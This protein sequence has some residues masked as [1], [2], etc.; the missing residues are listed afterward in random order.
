VEPKQIPKIILRGNHEAAR[1]MAR[2][3]MRQLDILK[4]LMSFGKLKQDVRRVEFIDG[5]EIICRSAFGIEDIQIYVPEKIAERE[6]T[7]QH[8]VY[9]TISDYVVI[10]SL[11]TGEIAEDIYDNEGNIEDEDGN[12]LVTFPCHKDKLVRWLEGISGK[13]T[14]QILK[15]NPEGNRDYILDNQ[16]DIGNESRVEFYNQYDPSREYYYGVGSPCAWDNLV[17]NT[18]EN[19]CPP[20]PNPRSNCRVRT[21]IEHDTPQPGYIINSDLAS[22]DNS[23]KA[24]TYGYRFYAEGDPYHWRDDTA[25]YLEPYR[26]KSKLLYLCSYPG[27]FYLRTSP[28]P[29]KLI[30]FGRPE[31]ASYAEPVKMGSACT[32]FSCV[33]SKLAAYEGWYL[34][35]LRQAGRTF[36]FVTVFGEF[37]A[38][39]TP[40]RG[41]DE[42]YISLYEVIRG[43]F[44][45]ENDCFNLQQEEGVC[46][47]HQHSDW[48]NPPGLGHCTVLERSELDRI[49]S[50]SNRFGISWC[51]SLTPRDEF[52]EDGKI[53]RKAKISG[54]YRVLLHFYMGGFHQF[55]HSCSTQAGGPAGPLQCIQETII[56]ETLVER[57]S[58]VQATI[59]LEKPEKYPKE[60]D[61][62]C[63]RYISCEEGTPE[64]IDGQKR[65]IRLRYKRPNEYAGHE[66]DFPSLCAFPNRTQGYPEDEEKELCYPFD[67]TYN[68]YTLGEA[69]EKL[70]DD[71]YED[72]SDNQ[73]IVY[74]FS[75]S[76][77]RKIP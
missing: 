54:W 49:D 14:R 59:E 48:E 8:Y 6:I 63:E 16:E 21:L 65:V 32:T 68:I 19:T 55:G 53:A 28:A 27:S 42:N 43:G 52:T 18:F 25:E 9:I 12:L 38:D 22:C 44:D 20:V 24:E 33:T 62:T 76:K 74:L 45:F 77:T 69:V 5:S 71:H 57:F 17:Q 66:E 29:P 4:N 35:Y 39:Y 23:F 40:T 46:A 11:E 67:G 50:E 72:E 15:D 56:P 70:I 61:D 26:A 51:G 60:L 7:L 10:W 41:L 13:P 58:S 64:C 2:E 34:Q 73:L 37:I 1:E 30:E 75:K 36:S 3:G 31:C 47:Y